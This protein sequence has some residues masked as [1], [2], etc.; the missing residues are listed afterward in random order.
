[1][2]PKWG[3]TGTNR[4][5]RGSLRALNGRIPFGRLFGTQFGQ[6][7]SE[8]VLIV[9][10]FKKLP[11]HFL[12]GRLAKN[13]GPTRVYPCDPILKNIPTNKPKWANIV[14]LSPN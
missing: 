6:R 9:N 8:R 14:N 1:M 4:V 13:R 3:K 5:G 2:G 10:I 7:K 12:Y 11:K